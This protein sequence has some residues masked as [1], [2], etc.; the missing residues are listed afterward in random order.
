M[1]LAVS[2]IA[3]EWARELERPHHSKSINLL[4]FCTLAAPPPF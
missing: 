1:K 3:K 2:G 4:L